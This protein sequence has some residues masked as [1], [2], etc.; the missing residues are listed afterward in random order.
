MAL[1]Q[2][3]AQQQTILSLANLRVRVGRTV[4]EM[5]DN[6]RQSTVGELR[7]M[8]RLLVKHPSIDPFVITKEL[9]LI[10]HLAHHV[11]KNRLTPKGRILAG[12]YRESVWGWSKDVEGKRA[13]FD[14]VADLSIQ[15]ERHRHFL[16]KLVAEGATVSLIL[17]LPGDVNIGSNLRST[18]MK[19]LADLGI[20]LGIEVFPKWSRTVPLT[21]QRA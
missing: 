19:R 1:G 16:S 14:E 5:I 9:G 7:F 13:F 11:G 4:S 12:Q 3:T 2:T 18:D 21:S 15:L 10:P 20:D 8:V 6:L 17:H